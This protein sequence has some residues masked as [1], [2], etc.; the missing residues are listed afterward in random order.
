MLRGAIDH[1]DSIRVAGWVHSDA[2]AV[3]GR[4]MLAYVD[5][6]CIGAGP[7]ATFRQ[8]LLDAGVGDGWAGFDFA[9]SPPSAESVS[10]LYVKFEL[11]DFILLPAAV[12]PAARGLPS[13]PRGT[14]PYSGATIEWMAARRWLDEEEQAFLEAML[15]GRPYVHHLPS[16]DV[17]DDTARSFIGLCLQRAVRLQ[18]THIQPRNLATERLRL[19][20]DAEI[21]VIA[22][23]GEGG[24]VEAPS[25]AAVIDLRPDRIVFVDASLPITGAG[26]GS[27]R[28]LRAA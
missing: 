22:I 1:I 16:V 21:P 26:T 23:H 11:S 15:T 19:V 24:S 14:L 6:R 7:V 25:A 12:V 28:L 8:D 3:R 17:A 4:T 13:A 2:D 20:E 10:R 27:A 18:H 5:D 9:I